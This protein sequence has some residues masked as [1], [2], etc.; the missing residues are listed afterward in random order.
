MTTEIKLTKGFMALV[1]EDDA[2]LQGL[3]WSPIVREGR[4]TYAVAN[5]PAT[6]GRD[7]RQIRMHRLIYS[8]MI[9]RKLETRE[10]VDHKNGN[11]LDC[12]RD[13]LRLATKQQNN[14]NRGI[15]RNNTSGYKGITLVKKT[16]KW[17]AGIGVNGRRIVLGTFDDP[18]IAHEV[19]CRAAAEAFGEFARFQ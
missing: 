2:D 9:G 6:K 8:R 10:E 14:Q 11:G 12:R 19:Y 1:D 3:K 18:V 4:P 5:D 7:R 16:G 17:R 15:Q 13:N